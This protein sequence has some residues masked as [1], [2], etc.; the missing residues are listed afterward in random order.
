MTESWSLPDVLEARTRAA[1]D[2]AFFSMMGEPALSVGEMALRSLRIANGLRELGVGFGDRVLVMLPNCTEF[3]EA[4]F[5]IN[6]LGAVLVTVNTAY[7]GSFLEHLA[8]NSGARVMIA[9]GAFVPVVLAS[10]DAMPGLERLVVVKPDAAQPARPQ[11]LPTIDFESLRAAPERGLDVRVTP[12]DLAA[13][14]YTSGTT[15]KS[16]GVMIPHA[17]MV[18][19]PHVYIDQLGIGR[20]DVFYSA[21][22][23]FHTNALALQV[24]GALIAGCRV[25]LAPQFS[26]SGWLPDVRASGATVTNL[27]GVMT[28]FVFRQPATPED[29]DNA[30]RIAS[31]VPM[32]A[33]APVFEQRFGVQLA[34]LYGS[35]EANCPLYQPRDE[36]RRDGACG[37]VVERWFECRIADPDTDH[38]L[39]HGEVGELQVRPKVAD[40]FMAGY[41]AMPE[42][43][44][45]A[46]RNLWFHT[47]DAMRRDA[48][49]YYY[50]VDRMKDC[51][52]RR[53]ENI[54][55]FEVEQVVMQHEGIEEAAAIGI[56]SPD[57]DNEQEVKIC[58]VAKPGAAA[59]AAALHAFCAARM[60][61][62]AVPRFIEFCDA[63]PKTPTQKV[64]K[65]EL[66]ERGVT[67]ETWV[68]P[69]PAPRVRTPS[70]SGNKSS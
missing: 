57:E 31:A 62:F 53:A 11:R 35:T 5:A 58:V 34:E 2:R 25:H 46:W 69:A 30:L 19:N 60:P 65:Q 54:S 29:A 48:D 4:W 18:L 41:N 40:G 52:R 24:Y 36:A 43:T 38:E 22:P 7:R 42:E 50:F 37:K 26:A 32:P 70:S 15:G 63:L 6:R 59:D 12:R 33:F 28:D 3:I 67:P 49:G 9:A 51:I 1:P 20:D 66:R 55:S 13:I 45:K 61:A 44:V 68:A 8:N 16:K 21:L 27:L 64:R 10:E 14:V 23:L 17:Q 47:G 56:R 39:P